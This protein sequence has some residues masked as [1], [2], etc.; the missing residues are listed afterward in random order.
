MSSVLTSAAAGLAAGVGIALPVGPISVLLVD[1]GIRHGWRRGAAAAAGVAAA[2]LCYALAAVLL[3]HGAAS[4]VGG[5]DRALRWGGA[6]LLGWLAVRGLRAAVRAGRGAGPARG[7][8]RPARPGPGG[9]RG[10]PVT[11]R[12]FALT[13]ANPLTIV[14]FSTLVAGLPPTRGG[15]GGAWAFVLGAGAGS[16]AWQLVLAGSGALTGRHAGL[17]VRQAL[18]VAGHLVVLALAA[19]MAWTATLG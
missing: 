9:A 17:R 1:A 11:V 8:R 12:F 16:L 19:V 10:L 4:W 18:G 5:H 14:Y 13:L 7:P 2:D 6:V 15:L 3:G